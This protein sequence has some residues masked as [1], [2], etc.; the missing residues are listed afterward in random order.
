MRI[1]SAVVTPSQVIDI[2]AIFEK[3][4]RTFHIQPVSI[5]GSGNVWV[6]IYSNVIGF[7][8]GWNTAESKPFGFGC[9]LESCQEELA[10]RFELIE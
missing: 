7:G 1:K 4:G 6:N 10:K 3:F 8:G 2:Q 9:F 5:R